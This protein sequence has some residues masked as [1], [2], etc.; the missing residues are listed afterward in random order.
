[1]SEIQILK[2]INKSIKSLTRKQQSCILTLLWFLLI[3]FTLMVMIFLWRVIG[4][5]DPASVVGVAALN[6]TV[7][8]VAVCIMLGSW[9]DW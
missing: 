8:T 9:G 3:P 6:L 5:F 2:M 4:I 7:M 1:M